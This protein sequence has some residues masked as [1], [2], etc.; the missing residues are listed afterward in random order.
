M[1]CLIAWV[2]FVGAISVFINAEV[3]IKKVVAVAAI[4]FGLVWGG[5]Q[6]ESEVSTGSS[7]IIEY[8]KENDLKGSDVD[9]MWIAAWRCYGDNYDVMMGAE[10]K[11]LGVPLEKAKQDLNMGEKKTQLTEEGYKYKKPMDIEIGN[12]SGSLEVETC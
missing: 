1:H 10:L 4:G 11:E 12:F 8:M 7:L 3:R 5:A 6:A 2:V 9:E